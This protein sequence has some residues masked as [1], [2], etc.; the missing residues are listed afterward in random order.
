MDG[1]TILSECVVSGRIWSIIE[2]MVALSI[3][4]TIGV[5]VMCCF[6][7]LTLEF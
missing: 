1:V 5:F 7:I 6:R 3:G 2:F 4:I